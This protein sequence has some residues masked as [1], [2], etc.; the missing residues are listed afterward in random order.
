MNECVTDPSVLLLTVALIL[1]LGFTLIV[2]WPKTDIVE[3]R[4]ATMGLEAKRF[5]ANLA[6]QHKLPAVIID[7]DLKPGEVGVFR[8][9]ST[10][11][12]TRNF[13]SGGA[14]ACN[15]SIQSIGGASDSHDW[16]LGNGADW[17]LAQEFDAG[18]LVLTSRRLVFDGSHERRSIDLV[19]VTSAKAWLDAIEITTRRPQQRQIYTVQNP[20]IWATMIQKLA[21][22]NLELPLAARI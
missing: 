6:K 21:R 7:I 2:C 22:G 11:V 18:T 9:S 20:W 16:S 17:E 1:I 8:E 3:D 5:F 13:P 14:G 10:L 15:G 19:D 4:P 12:E